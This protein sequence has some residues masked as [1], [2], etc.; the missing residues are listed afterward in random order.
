MAF[1]QGSRTGLSYVVEDSFGS[2]P[3]SPTMLTI[4][5]ATHSLGLS[6]E[7]VQG[8]DIL[9]DR[10]PRIDRH[11]TR[12]AEGNIVVDFRADDYDDFLESA[13]F[14]EIA[15]DGTMSTGITPKY[16]TI[17]DR[18]EDITQYRQF[19]G[20]AVSQMTMNV[21]PNQLIET[22]F[23]MMGQ[24][25]VQ[26][27]TSL[28]T[29]TDASG[30]NAFD[31]FSGDISEGGGT[32]TNISSIDFTLSNSL[33]PT[34]VVGSRTTPQLEYGRSVV[35]GNVSFYY[36]DETIIDKFLDEVESS[37]SFTL[38]DPVSGT[39]YTFNF[40]AVKFNGAAVPVGGPQ[41]RIV[42]V[43]FVAIYD[44]S[45]EYHLQLTKT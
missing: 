23:A 8:R 28:G 40:P 2:T 11:G 26:A 13:F 27:Q 35:T 3:G 32:V 18:A 12:M 1:A 17:E 42:A 41:S 16:L 15:T 36:E 6:K 4:P 5:Y 34:P 25:L 44:S 43:P 39:S 22:T 30:N 19:T 45:S 33:A 37:I 20:M 24:D 7:R 29:P 31:S 10:I 9:S 14:S 21:A 38:D